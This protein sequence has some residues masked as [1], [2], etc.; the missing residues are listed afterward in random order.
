MPFETQ[1]VGRE[2]DRDVMR[3]VAGIVKSGGK[4]PKS[5]VSELR[6]T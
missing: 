3:N 1:L 2:E 6:V 5:K 4:V